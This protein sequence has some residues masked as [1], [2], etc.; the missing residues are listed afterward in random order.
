MSSSFIHKSNS[1]IPINLMHCENPYSLS[2]WIA[3]LP[4][5]QS[6]V[7]YAVY[8]NDKLTDTASTEKRHIDKSD[9]ISCKQISNIF[10]ENSISGHIVYKNELFNRK[11]YESL[12]LSHGNAINI[13]SKMVQYVWEQ[14]NKS[15]K[16]NQQKRKH[17]PLQNMN[18]IQNT[19]D[20]YCYGFCNNQIEEKCKIVQ[21][22]KIKQWVNEDA[23]DSPPPPSPIALMSP[24]PV[25]P[26]NLINY[27]KFNASQT[28]GNKTNIMDPYSSI[29]S[30]RTLQLSYTSEEQFYSIA[31]VE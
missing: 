21:N 23:T 12:L 20:R 26:P 9:L 10:Y 15:Q 13:K 3:H 22:T 31:A 6:L 7:Y 19:F 16:Y 28:S 30:Q 4:Y 8:T 17:P 11:D 14:I 27:F 29:T 25:T 24:P 5:Y 1:D 18:W 2:F